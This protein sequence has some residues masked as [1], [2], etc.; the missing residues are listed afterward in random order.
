MFQ[1]YWHII[2]DPAHILAELTIEG[3]V[4]LMALIPF[5]TWVKRHDKKHHS[6]EGNNGR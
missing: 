2:T 4:A 5:R 3:V 6:V 1:E